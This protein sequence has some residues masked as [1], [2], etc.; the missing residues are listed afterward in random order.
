[1]IR[2]ARL[3]DAEGVHAIY[4]PVVRETAISF[5]WEVP[6]PSE[7]RRRMET[8]LAEG[9][10]WLVEM[11]EG[12]I[13][14]YAYASRFRG[15]RAYDWTAEVSIYVHPQH[16]GRGIGVA[17]YRR[18]LLLLEGQGYRSA[19]GV[20]TA[21]NPGS[22]ALHKRLGFTQVGTFP[23]VGYKGGAWHDI[24]LWHRSLG[25][26]DAPPRQLRSPSEVWPELEEG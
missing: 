15:R 8:L 6:D 10:P 18:I 11:E 26:D 7:I 21:P 22:A 9:F 24:T 3:E 17:L 14:G 2:L 12:E 1:M 19:V 20:A 5:E 23:S 25:A 13:R 16:Q 4:A